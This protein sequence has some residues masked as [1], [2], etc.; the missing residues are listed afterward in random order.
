MSSDADAESEVAETARY[1]DEQVIKPEL[2]DAF[3]RIVD[4]GQSR[5]RRPAR[6]VLATGAVAGIEVSLG[7]L[8]LLAVLAGGGNELVAGLAFSIGLVALLLGHSEL[9]TESFLI[10]VTTVVAGRGR[11]RDLLD[12]WLLVLVANLAGGWCMAFVIAKGFPDLHDQA[13][14]SAQ[15]YVE[16]PFGVRAL[17][18]AVLGGAAITLLTRMQHGT[19]DMVAKIA[20]AV[21]VGVLLGG[22]GLHHSVFDSL[23]AFVALD[24]GRA[25]FGYLDW[26]R[27]FS[28]AV[29]GNV[30]GGLGLVTMLRLVRSSPR[31]AE[32][33]EQAS[34]DGVDA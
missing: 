19:E 8:A 14:E 20:A 4:D 33:R 7:M 18:L 11:V 32:E 5:L 27:W 12:L 10:P 3:R 21:A 2:E 15:R 26:A 28:L 29:A 23:L 13:I 16:T 22:V 30:I 24:T 17:C 31:I 25:P 9:F 34:R 6:E 1:D